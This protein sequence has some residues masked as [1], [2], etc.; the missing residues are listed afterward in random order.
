MDAIFIDKN[1]NRKNFLYQYDVGQTFIIEDFP[2]SKAPKAQFSIKSIKQAVSVG[3]ELKGSDLHVKVPDTI[4]TYGENIVVYLYIEDTQSG[5][6][7]E[8]V[9][10]SVIP[11]KMPSDYM[12]TEEM[13]VRSID[14]TIFIDNCGVA[15]VATWIDGNANN[16]DRYGYFVS[17]G[18]NTYN[19]TLTATKATSINDVYGVSVDQ[20]GLATNCNEDKLD[21]LGNLLLRYAYVCT[22]GFAKV[23]DNGSCTVGKMCVP[24]SQGIAVASNNDVGYKV[25]SRVD[26]RH[27]IIFVDPSMQTIN[28]FQTTMNSTN[29]S[30]NSHLQNTS[31]PHRVNKEQVGLGNCDNTSDIN[32]PVSEAQSR[33][34]SQVQNNL[35]THADRSDNPHSVTKAQVGLGNVP[36]VETNNQTPTYTES[37][38]LSKMTSGEILS[39]AFGK[40]SKAVSDL[41]AHIA[42]NNNPHGVTKAQVGLGNCDNTSDANKPVSTAQSTAISEA[43]NEVQN[44]LK[45]HLDDISNPHKVTAHQVGAYTQAETD[46]KIAGL[47]DTAPEALNTLNEL[48]AALGD[49]EN[50][51]TTMSTELGKKATKDE[52]NAHV[53]RS[54]NPHSVTKEQVGLSNVDNTSDA[55]KPISTATQTALDKKAD[56]VDGIVPISQLPTSLTPDTH[57]DTHKIGGSDALSYSDI[58]AAAEAHG[59]DD[60]YYTKQEIND[61]IED[62]TH[63]KDKVGLD[64][65]DNTSD[66]DKP[67]SDATQEALNDINDTIAELASKTHASTHAVGGEDELAPEDIG[68]VKQSDFDALKLKVDSLELSGGLAITDSVTG[69]QYTLGMQDG[70][71]VVILIDDGTITE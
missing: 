63:T 27:V 44:N 28:T 71:L 34:I 60:L 62:H 49:D 21:R 56:L 54:D 50:F 65:V 4:L 12:F 67:I 42:N 26:D 5:S 2:Y 38:T 32:K 39:V 55:N 22:S 3:S 48:A 59:H 51:A 7:V 9:F 37:S 24:N 1:G 29:D 17:V 30:L 45:N 61:T 25:V 66:K 33:A 57:A 8:T 14:G 13:F 47:V 40:I 41:I 46:A 52:F 58:G 11:R 16:E 64:K 10:I 69:K 20:V 31:N 35:N 18:Y 36:N 6:T 15:D 19:K 68:A 70:K 53:N 23:I 43:K